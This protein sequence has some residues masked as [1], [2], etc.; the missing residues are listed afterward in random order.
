M[1]A[2]AESDFQSRLASLESRAPV[3]RKLDKLIAV[4]KLAYDKVSRSLAGS[5]VDVEKLGRIQDRLHDTLETC[6]QAR[7]A[8]EDQGR[9]SPE[10]LAELGDINPELAFQIGSAAH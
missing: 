9:L 7:A 2:D 1:H 8:L 10:L 5:S 4:L 3:L 6:S